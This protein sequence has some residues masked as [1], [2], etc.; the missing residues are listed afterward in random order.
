MLHIVRL[1]AFAIN[2]W[3]TWTRSTNAQRSP[4]L[5]L[6]TKTFMTTTRRSMRSTSWGI[7]FPLLYCKQNTHVQRLNTAVTFCI[8][9]K[10]RRATCLKHDFRSVV[11]FKHV[12]V[13]HGKCRRVK[14]WRLKTHTHRAR[15]PDKLATSY[16]PPKSI[17]CCSITW[18]RN[19]V[20]LWY[21][22][23]AK[24]TCLPE[25]WGSW[26]H[27]WRWYIASRCISQNRSQ[28]LS[29]LWRSGCVKNIQ[30]SQEALLWPGIVTLT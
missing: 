29:T 22:G 17:T 5:T 28:V 30:D 9:F 14:G 2:S 11:W 13:R 19:G 15:G 4:R 20:L 23:K 24:E 10:F 18:Q 8:R 25:H 12:H 21:T 6:F 1:R 26:W 7:R 27:Y 3:S 16:F